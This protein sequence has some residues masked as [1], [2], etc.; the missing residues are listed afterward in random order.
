MP[1]P[2]SDTIYRTIA[3]NKKLITGQEQ[4][5]DRLCNQL[6]DM[7]M[8]NTTS[9]WT[10]SYSPRSPAVKRDALDSSRYTISICLFII[11]LLYS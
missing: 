6:K 7:R 4:L 1:T 11:N 5:I 10:T 3:T 8:Y 2:A 9:N